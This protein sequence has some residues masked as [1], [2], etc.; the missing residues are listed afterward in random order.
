MFMINPNDIQKENEKKH[1]LKK[2]HI[3]TF[4][5]NTFRKYFLLMPDCVGVCTSIF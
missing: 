4:F 5:C 3:Y 1:R 2:D